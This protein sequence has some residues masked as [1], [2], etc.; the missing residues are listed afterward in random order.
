LIEH[1]IYSIPVDPVLLANKL[2]VTVSNAVFSDPSLSGM[3]AKR[4][5]ATSLLVNDNDAA[6]RKRFTIAHELGH[7]LLH[8]QDDGEFVDSEIDLFRSGE[9]DTYEQHTK[10]V[11]A[12]QFAAAL[13]MD[14]EAVAEQWVKCKSIEALSEVFGVSKEAMGIRLGSL[15]VNAID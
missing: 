10:E 15:G 2:G 5:S 8:L 4:G 9:A 11:E 12:N 14:A 13:L 1:G 7:K 6:T 3:I